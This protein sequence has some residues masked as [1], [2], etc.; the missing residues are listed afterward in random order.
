M[1]SPMN[2]ANVFHW[3]FSVPDMATSLEAW[4]A[5]GADI[6]V[7]PGEAEGLDVICCFIVYRGAPIELVAPA[8]ESGRQKLA[9]ILARGGGLDHV[10]YFTTDMAS[11]LEALEAT[12]NKLAIPPIYNSHFDRRLAFL[13]AP[14]GLVIELMERRP[15]GKLTNDP[16]QIYLRQLSP[17]A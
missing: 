5:Q 11:D 12:G 2:S 17:P 9:P 6:I 10:C 3:G 1:S 15:S 16:L 4:K 14:T 8:N 7:P 13:V